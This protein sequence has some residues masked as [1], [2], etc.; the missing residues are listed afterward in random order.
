[1]DIVS[2]IATFLLALV[3]VKAFRTARAAVV[4]KRD[5]NNVEN[6]RKYLKLRLGSMREIADVQIALSIATDV[7]VGKCKNCSGEK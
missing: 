1:M 2:Y 6:A 5:I 3:L 7:R 4:W